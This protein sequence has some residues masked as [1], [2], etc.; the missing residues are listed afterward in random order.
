MADFLNL[1]RYNWG[2]FSA[3]ETG[4]LST[5]Y[6][7]IVIVKLCLSEIFRLAVGLVLESYKNGRFLELRQT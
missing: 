3:E 4:T 2:R 6:W 1:D 7:V 5:R